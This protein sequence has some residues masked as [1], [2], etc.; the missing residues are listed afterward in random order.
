MLFLCWLLRVLWFLKST[1]SGF[2]GATNS[3]NHIFVSPLTFGNFGWAT[4]IWLSK[5]QVECHQPRGTKSTSPAS[6]MQTCKF[7]NLEVFK[8]CHGAF[9]INGGSFGDSK[10]HAFRPLTL[11]MGDTIL[12]ESATNSSPPE[13]RPSLK[14]T[15]LP[16][17]HFQVRAVSFRTGNIEK[18]NDVSFHLGILLLFANN[19][20]Y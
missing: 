18:S 11:G 14:E 16:I 5:F 15:S 4:A 9:T 10:N 3:T 1:F 17:I 13:N 2:S 7:C 20:T 19:K 12:E 6:T 8:I